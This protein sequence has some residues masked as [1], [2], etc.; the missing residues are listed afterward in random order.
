MITLIVCVVTSVWIHKTCANTSDKKCK[1]MQ[2]NKPGEEI[3]LCIGCLDFPFSSI[4][5]KKLLLLHENENNVTTNIGLTKFS[6]ICSICLRKL[7]KP[8]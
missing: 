1:D 7:G 3:W 4:D 8:L 2:G 5:N 6:I